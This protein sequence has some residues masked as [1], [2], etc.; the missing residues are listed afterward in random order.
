MNV[1]KDRQT[2]M[3][4][5]QDENSNML[6]VAQREREKQWS[7]EVRQMQL[8]AEMTETTGHQ[9]QEQRMVEHLPRTTSYHQRIRTEFSCRDEHP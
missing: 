3:L 2:R 5:L 1:A 8:A 6:E 7:N 9:Y 4:E